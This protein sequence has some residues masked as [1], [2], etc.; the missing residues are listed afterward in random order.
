MLCAVFAQAAAPAPDLAWTKFIDDGSGC[1]LSYPRA[2]F[3]ATRKVAGE[4]QRFSSEDDD[5]YFRLL[6]TDNVSRW[7]P[8]D[9]KEKYLAAQMPG[10]IVYDRTRSDFVV[11][12]GYRGDN[13]FYTKV[14]ISKDLGKACILDITYP[15]AQKKRF[16]GIVTR[17]S[18][19][20][21]IGG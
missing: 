6:I 2:I 7:T 19:S 14:V 21:A 1:R 12:S 10:L 16:D 15:R 17:M 11:L 4:P 3:S 13:I 18:H 8:S 20:F 9:L 5:I